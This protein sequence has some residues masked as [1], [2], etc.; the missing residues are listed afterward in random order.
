[1]QFSAQEEYGLRCLLRL[2]S[3]GDGASMTIPE[4]SQAEGM[5][6]AYVAKLMRILREGK[7]VVS[8]R[9]Q[10]G[11]YRLVRAAQDTTAAEALAVLGGRIFDDE[12]CTDR[13]VGTESICTRS[14][15]CSI[16]SLWQVVQTVV[17]QVL[18]KTTL[19]DLVRTEGEMTAF[20]QQLVAIEQ[21]AV[22]KEPALAEQP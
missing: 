20:M 21:V 12:F 7:M 13:Y 11:G 22:A 6:Q 10:S 1:M 17:D 19:Q 9:G 16:R 5:S 4:I 15:N 8:E 14:V 3:A 18:T 2:A